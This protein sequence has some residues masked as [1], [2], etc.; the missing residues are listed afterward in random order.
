M[1]TFVGSRALS[2]GE[3]DHWTQPS[4]SLAGGLCAVEKFIKRFL[5]KE[6]A[7]GEGRGGGEPKQH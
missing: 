3:F 5:S 4:R 1:G 7:W 6:K 2:E